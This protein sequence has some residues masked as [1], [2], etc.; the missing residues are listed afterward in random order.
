[1]VA[2]VPVAEAPR[3]RVI[4]HGSPSD[5]EALAQPVPVPLAALRLCSAPGPPLSICTPRPPPQQPPHKQPPTII[6]RAPPQQPPHHH[7]LA[8]TPAATA[9]AGLAPLTP[10]AHPISP[11]RHPPHSL[12]WTPRQMRGTLLRGTPQGA[13]KDLTA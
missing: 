13:G 1:M 6:P 8:P 7:P 4:E 11:Q 2:A 10:A 12:P 5:S 3:G 9:P